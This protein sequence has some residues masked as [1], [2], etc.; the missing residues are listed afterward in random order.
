MSNPTINDFL[1][2]ISGKSAAG[3]SAALRNLRNPEGVVYL[4]CESNK[5]LP[6]KSKFQEFTV[7]DPFQVLECFDVIKKGELKAHTVVI[8]SL[9]FLLDM[10]ES[11]YVI[12]SANTMAGWQN[13]QQYF[14]TLMQEKVATSG[15]NVI[16]NAHTADTY[17][18]SE[19]V[20]E[21]KVPV[22]G[23]LKGNG[24]EA[25]FSCVIAAKRV[26][27]KTLEGYKSDLLVITPQEEI[28][29]FKYVFQTRVT[30]NTINE[31]IRSPMA[32]FTTA[33]T[34]IDNDVQKLLDHLHSY[35]E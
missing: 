7:T 27:L 21:T 15:I 14:K 34:F 13:F 23:A 22:K 33:E 31:R 10:Y 35:Y 6:F 19:M 24:I 20:T 29:G 17:N 30:K 12:G 28:D 4:N 1:V 26:T 25:Y 3:K 5:K 16:F 18:E 9:T 8:D 2:L 32:L 11:V